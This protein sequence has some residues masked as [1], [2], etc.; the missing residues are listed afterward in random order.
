MD[1][2]KDP[3]SMVLGGVGKRHTFCIGY[4]THTADRGVVNCKV[5]SFDSMVEPFYTYMAHSVC[6]A[7]FLIGL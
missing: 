1:V 6:T 2:F 5:K 3:G 4:G 7:H